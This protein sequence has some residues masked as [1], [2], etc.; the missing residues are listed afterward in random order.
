MDNTHFITTGL[1]LGNYDIGDAEY[2]GNSLTTG[3]ELGRHPNGEGSLVI[4]KRGDALETGTAPGRRA[5]VPHTNNNGG[6]NSAGEDLLVKA[7]LWTSRDDTDGDGVD[8]YLDLDSDNDGIYDVIE[9]GHD[10]PHTSGRLTGAVGL[11]GVYDGIQ[12][13]G[14]E[15][16]RNYKLRGPRFGQ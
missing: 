5:I 3:T 6:F 12:N 13:A 14:Q 7:I 8:D 10:Q 1:S 15:D 9:A 2:Y 4:W 11:D 16:Q